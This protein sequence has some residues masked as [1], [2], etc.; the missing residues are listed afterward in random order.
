MVKV[1]I[2]NE[3]LSTFL[4]TKDLKK[5][6][7]SGGSEWELE[8]TLQFLV[9]KKGELDEYENELKINLA[10]I[11]NAEENILE[12]IVNFRIAAKM[13]YPRKFPDAHFFCFVS[14]FELQGNIKKREG[15][16]VL[17]LTQNFAKYIKSK[18]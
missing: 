6:E 11:T 13:S 5:L 15:T 3:Y 16:V 14:E 1:T 10:Q 17:K 4:E 7:I 18:I 12:Q 2:L 8:S 9:S